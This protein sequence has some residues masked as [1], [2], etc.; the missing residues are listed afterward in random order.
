VRRQIGSVVFVGMVESGMYAVNWGLL[1][2]IF[3]SWVVT[4]P[5]AAL[6]AALF[7]GALQGV[8]VNA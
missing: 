5:T 1:S 6:L 3:I 4:V 7:F 8:H 2:R